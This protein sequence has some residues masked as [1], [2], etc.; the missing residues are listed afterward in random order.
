MAHCKRW[1]ISF[2]GMKRLVYFVAD[3]SFVN[4][5][6]LSS[7]QK[8]DTGEATVAAVR[9]TVAV[10]EPTPLSEISK[11]YF[12]EVW[13]RVACKFAPIKNLFTELFLTGRDFVK[14]FPS[15]FATYWETVSATVVKFLK[16]RK[17]WAR[18]KTKKEWAAISTILVGSLMFSGG[19]LAVMNSPQRVASVNLPTVE[20]QAAKADGKVVPSR[21]SN[22]A[23]EPATQAK[24]NAGNTATTIDLETAEVNL[25]SSGLTIPV[26]ISWASTS[27]P[28]A[29]AS[30]YRPTPGQKYLITIDDL[31]DAAT[32]NEDII[33]VAAM[34]LTASGATVSKPIKGANG[35][36]TFS[37]VDG[38]TNVEVYVAL[39]AG[40]AVMFTLTL[41]KPN[42]EVSNEVAWLADKLS[43]A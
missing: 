2:K 34:A 21:G 35:V 33:D 42:I 9:E 38:T 15:I 41:S 13:S 25:S 27:V 18:T 31:G 10:N 3:I 11:T 24:V 14:A 19:F 30:F 43:K 37:A 29:D 23:K 39:Y 16:T 28:G 32:I 12:S 8:E 6:T 22:T 4:V 40:K 5:E 17:G 26:P 20:E 36:V 1:A 7:G